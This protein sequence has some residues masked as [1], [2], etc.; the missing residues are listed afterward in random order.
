LKE[1]NNPDEFKNWDRY[2]A[3][4]FLIKNL[5]GIGL[6]HPEIW[7]LDFSNGLRRYP[8]IFQAFFYHPIRLQ[9]IKHLLPED[10]YARRGFLLVGP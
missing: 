6:L 9:P 2:Q 3:P 10:L 1:R 4:S 5:S 8:S 7:S